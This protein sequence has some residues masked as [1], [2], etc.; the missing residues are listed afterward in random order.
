MKR[1]FNL[2]HIIALVLTAGILGSALRFWLFSS[3]IDSKGLIIAK[4]PANALSFILT[5][6]VLG[7]LYVILRRTR[8]GNL[9]FSASLPAAIGCWIAALGILLADSYNPSDSQDNVAVISLILGLAAIVALI[10]LGVR[11]L[12]GTRPN[13]LLRSCITI[14]LMVHLISQYRVWSGEPQLQEY[15]FQLTASVFLMLATYHRTALDDGRGNRRWAAFFQLGALFFCCLAIVDGD[16]PFYFSMALWTA[17][18]IDTDNTPEEMY[19]PKN[20]LSPTR[21]SA[22]T[23]AITEFAPLVFVF[24][25]VFAS[26]K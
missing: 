4:H 10:A 12:R 20:V 23:L 11:H 14:Y 16:R 5:A 22:A 24:I 9:Q 18:S 8:T 13:I 26:G 25:K 1:S 19:L 21:H 17:L 15:F 2:K 3:G 7:A 6:V